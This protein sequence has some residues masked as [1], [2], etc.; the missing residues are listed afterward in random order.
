MTFKY[1]YKHTDSLK[2]NKKNTKNTKNMIMNK[3]KK[4]YKATY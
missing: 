2:I 3:R 4:H 1:K